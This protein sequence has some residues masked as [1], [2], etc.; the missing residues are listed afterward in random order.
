MECSEMSLAM[1]DALWTIAYLV[2]QA[3][4]TFITQVCQG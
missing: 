4:D 3:D 2:E 1:T